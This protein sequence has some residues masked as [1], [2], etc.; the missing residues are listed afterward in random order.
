MLERIRQGQYFHNRN[1]LCIVAVIFMLFVIVWAFTGE[2]I[3]SG[4]T[5]HEITYWTT[6]W[7][8]VIDGEEIALEDIGDFQ[9]IPVGDTLVLINEVPELTSDMILF[10]YTKDLEVNVYAGDELLYSFEMQEKF[11]FLDTPGNKWNQVEI[12]EELSGET[13]RIEFTS[14][15]ANRYSSTVTALALIKDYEAT[16]IVLKQDSYRIIMS[17]VVLGMTIS[18]FVDAFIWKRKKV[19]KYFIALGMFCLSATLW[20]FSMS[21][22]FN[23]MWNSPIV[24][25]L[26]S[27]LMV[28]VIPVTLY[29]FMDTIYDGKSKLC[30]IL[31]I[32]VWADFFIQFILQF[33]FHVSFLTLLP[34][35]YFVYAAGALCV[36][37][38]IIQYLIDYKKNR[39]SHKELNFELAS[40]LIIFAGALVEIVVLC[41]APER[42]DLIGVAGIFGLFIYLIINQTALTM[43]EAKT[44][45]EKIILEENYNALQ[46]TTLIQQIKAHFFFNTLNTISAL[47]KQDPDEAD[48]AIKLFAKYM[49][50]YMYLI[51]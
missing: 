33:V 48:R 47:C 18:A 35:T 10:F 37:Y 29:E 12:P 16:A 34:L 25:Y 26:I 32:V 44:D 15:F 1:K 17:I 4:I 36:F 14:Q 30:K 28:S 27:L 23:Y 50:S 9:E 51:N 13:L 41:V 20:L 2:T 38:M 11:E 5:N 22:L 45:M 6:G 21:G 7:T 8:Q 49:R 39:D 3:P 40:T 43:Y 31:G 24:S 19:K 42:T 46:N